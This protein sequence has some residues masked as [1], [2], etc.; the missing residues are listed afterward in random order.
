MNAKTKGFTLVELLIVIVIISILAALIIVTYQGMQQRTREVKQDA[1]VSQLVKAIGVARESSGKTL[2]EI[3]GQTWTIGGCEVG[4]NNPD[5]TEPRNL[6]KSHA[7]WTKYYSAIDK[8]A[9]ASGTNLDAIK[10]GDPR[11]NP[12]N[13]DENEGETSQPCNSRDAIIKYSGSG[14]A[15]RTLVYI[16]QFSSHC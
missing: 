4:G 12:Y 10:N 11:G 9:T 8:I 5:G 13:I 6:P 3:T 15:R 16:S 2:R 14:V 7:C 1:D